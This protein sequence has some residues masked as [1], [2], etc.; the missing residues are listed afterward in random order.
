VAAT[1]HD[2]HR[3]AKGCLAAEPALIAIDEPGATNRT[4]LTTTTFGGVKADDASFLAGVKTKLLTERPPADL[5]PG[6]GDD[7]R[8][9]THPAPPTPQQTMHDTT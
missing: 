4:N 6:S 8:T 2:R 1:H 7:A 9:Q 3:T 5:D